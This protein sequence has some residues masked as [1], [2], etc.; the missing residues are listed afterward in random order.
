[1]NQYAIVGPDLAEYKQLT[2]KW[3][4]NYQRI[5]G[6]AQAMDQIE[7]HRGPLSEIKSMYV[8]HALYEPGAG[9][10]RYFAVNQ[11]G[12]PNQYEVEILPDRSWLTLMQSPAM[13]RASSDMV[14][15]AFSRLVSAAETTDNYGCVPVA[16]RGIET[17]MIAQFYDPT[18]SSDIPDGRVVIR[19]Q[20]L[21]I[22]ST[23][24]P[25]LEATDSV[26]MDRNDKEPVSDGKLEDN[27]VKLLNTKKR[28]L[29]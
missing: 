8:Q 21:L 1:M 29:H 16:W 3:Q 23:I 15:K 17:R 7:I 19:P 27:V 24:L 22:D 20:W 26:P 13:D 14:D 9:G 6:L 2:Q 10:F 11:D 25:R 12:G 4:R 28:D 5:A 18:T